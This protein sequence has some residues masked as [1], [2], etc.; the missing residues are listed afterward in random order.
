MTVADTPDCHVD[1]LEITYRYICIK[2]GIQTTY[3]QEIG[4]YIDT[5]ISYNHFELYD[6]SRLEVT[7]DFTS[8]IS[9]S[10]S[11]GV[12]SFY[13][14]VKGQCFGGHSSWTATYSP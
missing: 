8:G 2:S 4:K 9:A 3:V 7:G 13:D 1:Y 10:G 11:C 6:S 14:P 5:P 12:S